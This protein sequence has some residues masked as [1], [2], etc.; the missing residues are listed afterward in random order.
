MPDFE[1]R[2]EFSSEYKIL[3]G[4]DACCCG[5]SA[6]PSNCDDCCQ[7][8]GIEI[9]SGLPANLTPL[10]SRLDDLQVPLGEPCVWNLS[11]S[12]DHNNASD[13]FPCEI[14]EY[15]SVGA[16]IY[17]ENDVDG[18]AEWFLN[19]YVCSAWYPEGDCNDE[20]VWWNGSWKVSLG[21]GSCPSTSL[22]SLNMPSTIP[23][24]DP[25]TT[26]LTCND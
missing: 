10:G 1:Y 25:I 24:E 22:G 4:D 20:L 13:V 6:C 16:S 8:I 18:C 15:M 14:L 11:Q 5:C 2:S 17:C 26:T 21:G 3:S 12:F 9:T 23:G 7:S 19:L